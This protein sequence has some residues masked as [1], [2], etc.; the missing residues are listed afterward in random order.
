VGA[1]GGALAAALG[2]LGR[3]VTLCVRTPFEK[4]VRVFQDERRSYDHPV[5]ASP[6]G[7][8]PVDWL[9]LCTKTYQIEG[10]APWLE[11]LVGPDTRIAVMQNGVDHQGRMAAYAPP[12]RV[13][14]GIILLPAQIES[15]GVVVQGRPG[16]VNVPDSP[17]GRALCKLFENNPLVE[18]RAQADFATEVWKKLVVNAA[19]GGIS[20]L[21]LTPVG[22][23]SNPVIRDLAARLMQE[24][25]EVGRAEGATIPDSFVDECLA[26]KP[27]GLGGHFPSITVD[28]REGR[29]MEWEARNAVVGKIGRRHGLST[30][31]NDVL[32]ALL[33]L[34]DE[35]GSGFNR[36]S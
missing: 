30:P 33:S 13:V 7:L 24:I 16:V 15:P 3:E 32:T 31:L 17:A 5:V 8:E 34:A 4:L 1:I 2:D 21:T 6:S 27:P 28:W 29:P 25:I 36:S 26:E 11:K 10:A 9:L 22:Q 20:T 23:I 18:L 12:E 14:P 19:G 35:H